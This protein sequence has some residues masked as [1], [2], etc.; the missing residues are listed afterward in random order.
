MV[1]LSVR[2]CTYR[3]RYSLDLVECHMDPTINKA[4]TGRRGRSEHVQC[5]KTQH[6]DHFE[7]VRCQSWE[8]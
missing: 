7:R 5:Q 2:F 6:V 4:S 8:K 3:Y 1:I